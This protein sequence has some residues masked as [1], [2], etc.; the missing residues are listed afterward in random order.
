[1]PKLNKYMWITGREIRNNQMN[2]TNM[3]R[4]VTEIH[5]ELIYQEQKKKELER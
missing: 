3:W 1:M 2:H 4:L 5:G